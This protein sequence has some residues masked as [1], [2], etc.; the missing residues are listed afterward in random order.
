V[1]TEAPVA[2][3]ETQ[4]GT[5]QEP[6]PEEDPCDCCTGDCD[7]GAIEDLACSAKRFQKQA[8]VVTASLEQITKFRDKFATARASYQAAKDASTADV[9]AA[10][11]QLEDVLGQLRCRLADDTEECLDHALEKVVACIRKCAGEPG[12]CVGPCEFDADPGTDTAPALM[13]RIE[14]Y[15]RDV[16]QSAKCFDHLIEEITALPKRATALKDEVASIADDACSEQSPKDWVQL[17]ARA[18]VAEW[19]LKDAQLYQGFPTVNDFV[20]CLCQALMCVLKGW[21]AIALLEGVAAELDC[22]ADAAEAACKKKQDDMVG[23]VL[24]CYDRC[25]TDKGDPPPPDDCDDEPPKKKPCGCGGH[26]H[27]GEQTSD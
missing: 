22:K 24:S 6:P 7:P 10:K 25:C 15:R 19:K 9:T 16:D 18:V 1:D 23:E 11:K 21:E 3:P 17:Y 5:H 2:Q 12:C 14:Q 27:D 8:E 26:H 4:T 13:G 20:D